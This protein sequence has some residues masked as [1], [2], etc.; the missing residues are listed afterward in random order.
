MFSK[1]LLVLLATAS[2]ASA[3]LVVISDIDDTIKVS[4]VLDKSESVKNAFRTENVFRGMPELYQLIQGNFPTTSFYYLSNA[5]KKIMEK[6]HT[7]FLIDNRFPKGTLLT[8]EKISDENHKVNSIR[9]ILQ[10]TSIT[11]ILYLGDNAERDTVIYAQMVK[12]FP[13]IPSLT[14]IRQAYS[15]KNGEDTGKPLEGNQMGF[16]SPVEVALELRNVRVLSENQVTALEAFFVHPTIKYS[17]QEDN[18]G[19]T[20]VL[21][22]PSW[23][24]CR[25]YRLSGSLAARKT[26]YAKLLIHRIYGR[27]ARTAPND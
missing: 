4:H 9:K 24:D 21:S 17:H 14:F 1:I 12:E 7:K 25:D 19:K 15:V 11:A 6:S 13:R 10:D 18:F 5:P 23:V 3:R 27:C 26:N 16:V 8:R 22:F 20:G 2:L